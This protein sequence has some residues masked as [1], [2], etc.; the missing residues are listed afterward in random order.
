MY[1]L[2]FD[3]WEMPSSPANLFGPVLKYDIHT[4]IDIFM[5][6]DATVYVPYDGE[7][8]KIGWFT[9][10][11]AEPTPSPWWND[12]QYVIIRHHALGK[13]I[14]YGEIEVCNG[15]YVGKVVQAGDML[16]NIVQVLKRD[17]G[18]PMSMLHIE[19]YDSI[20]KAPAIWKLNESCPIGLE[21]PYDFLLSLKKQ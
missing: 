10:T 11:N 3:K 20:E 19:Q 13:Y 4:G 2:F 6:E 21:D 18:L 8:V 16:G 7:V 5:H 15:L 1:H 12:T 14:L 17:K 9:G